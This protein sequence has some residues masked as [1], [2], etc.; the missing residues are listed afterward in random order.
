MGED[1]GVDGARLGHLFARR[2]VLVDAVDAHR[3]RIIERHQNIL[4]GN[5]RADVDRARRK[6]YRFAVRRQSATFGIDAKSGDVMLGAGRAITRS[7]AAGRN[8]KIAPRRMRPGILHARG[9]R[10]LR[11]LDQLRAR[12][13]YIVMRE[14]GSDI[15]IER[16]LLRRLLGGSQ[17]RCGH[18][19]CDK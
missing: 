19:A 13:I 16:G 4:G 2:K 11:A 15:C 1:A 5:I 7:A 6:A 3:A 18:A 9:Q 8:I 10:D 17:S 14:I 12:D